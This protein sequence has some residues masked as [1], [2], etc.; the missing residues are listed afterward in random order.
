MNYVFLDLET[1]GFAPSYASIIEVAALMVEIKD[2]V[3]TLRDS[4][5]EYIKPYGGIPAKITE[6]TGISNDMVAN[7]DCEKKVLQNLSMWLLGNGYDKFEVIAHNGKFD[8]RFLTGR[9]SLYNLDCFDYM[10]N[11]LIDT[12][13]IARKLIK[14]GKITTEDNSAKLEC[15]ANAFNVQ[16]NAHSALEDTKALVKVYCNMRKVEGKL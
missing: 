2:G 1:T 3:A 16:F 11:C 10:N 7:C 5:H 8:V 4:F 13:P 12:L 14:E 6:L 9:G 15:L